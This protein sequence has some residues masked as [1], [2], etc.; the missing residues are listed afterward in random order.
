M[1][2][3]T[4]WVQIGQCTSSVRW[5]SSVSLIGGMGTFATSIRQDAFQCPK[6]MRKVR[7]FVRK[8]PSSF[9][10]RS[11]EHT[12]FSAHWAQCFKVVFE[13]VGS[14]NAGDTDAVHFDDEVLLVD[15]DALHDLPEV[16]TGFGD[17]QAMDYLLIGAL[18]C[19]LIF[20]FL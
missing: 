9:V 10:A 8:A 7:A 16:D 5:E 1:R 4:L 20:S 2:A 19:A 18:I 11:A 3:G 12:D 13:F 15:V 6:V 17:G 14:Y